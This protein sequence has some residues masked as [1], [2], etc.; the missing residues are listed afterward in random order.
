MRLA[1]KL[2]VALIAVTAL[3][4]GV[5]GWQNARRQMAAAERGIR[6]TQWTIG[7]ALRPA[8]VHI[9]QTEGRSRAL[10]M[11]AYANERVRRARA[12]EI[13]CVSL[14][15]VEPGAVLP[16]VSLQD[17]EPLAKQDLALHFARTEGGAEFLIT[18]LP[19]VVGG[20]NVGALEIS[21]SLSPHRELLNKELG[22]IA[23]RTVVSALLSAGAIAG[24][25]LLMIGRP[26][27]RLLAKARRVGLGDLTGPLVVRG[28]DELAELAAEMNDMCDRL[29]AAQA[30]A[31]KESDARIA[32]IE[33]LRHADR[34]T[35]VGTL[36]SGIAHELGTPL[37]VV[38]GRARMIAAGDLGRAE[39]MQDARTIG[40]Q[41]ERMTSII[42]QLL[43]FARRGPAAERTRLELTALVGKMAALLE[44]MARRN[45]VSIVRPPQESAVTVEADAVHLE[46]AIANLMVNGIQAMREGGTLEVRVGTRTTRPPADVG[47]PERP[48]AFIEVLDQGAGILPEHVDRVFEPF[49]TTKEVGEGTG[50]GLSVA[51]GIIRDHGGWIAVESQNRRGSRF[52]VFLPLSV[53]HTGS[54]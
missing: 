23:S 18:Y 46:Q 34:L 9:W 45:Q 27:R 12:V 20:R 14:D 19:V 50:L 41:V 8:L 13:R 35:T 29:A 32:A 53:G 25:G 10:E 30:R 43:D 1:S 47:D 38:L 44:P 6:E 26:I 39:T 51:Y 22:A 33:Q 42:R 16:R 37:N 48:H 31:H 5:R 2:A 21:G 36:A 17:L 49:F 15:P 3:I 24:L 54:R 28:R 52:T 4:F 11:V 40:E 7:R